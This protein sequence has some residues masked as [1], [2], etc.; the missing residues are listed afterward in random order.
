MHENARTV[1]PLS[2]HQNRSVFRL[3]SV[4]RTIELDCCYTYSRDDPRS[5]RYCM[6]LGVVG[7]WWMLWRWP[8]TTKKLRAS[9]E[10]V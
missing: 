1:S 9:W 8:L 6:R 7:M 5:F 2:Y 4:P 3:E 10:G